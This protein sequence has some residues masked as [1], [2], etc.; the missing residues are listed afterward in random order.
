MEC[1]DSKSKIRFEV[2]GREKKSEKKKCE[3]MERE[4]TYCKN[5][6]DMKIN[7]TQR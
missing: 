1:G 3:K 2:E 4:K 6:G 7:G 5:L